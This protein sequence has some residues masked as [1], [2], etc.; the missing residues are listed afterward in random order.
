MSGQSKVLIAY[1][2]RTGNVKGI[3][4]IIREQTG[5][6]I[7]KIK[8]TKPYS[9]WYML[10]VLRAG[11]EMTMKQEVPIANHVDNIDQYDT[12]FVGTP[13]WCWHCSGPVKTFLKEHNLAGKRIIPFCSHGGG[14]V[15]SAFDEIAAGCPNSTILEGFDARKSEAKDNPASL[16]AW[17]QKVMNSDSQ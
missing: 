13:V 10:A 3:A 4:E 1:F 8:P 6:D 15:S 5:G 14:G 17:I 11:K 2:S 9:S 12:I 7:F 16:I